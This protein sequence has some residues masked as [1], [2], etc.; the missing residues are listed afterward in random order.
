[1]SSNLAWPVTAT[2][3][4]G[5]FFQR[6]EP[7]FGVTLN[8]VCGGSGNYGTCAA[9]VMVPLVF[10]VTRWAWA[11]GISLGI[12]EA[13]FC[14]DSPLEESLAGQKDR[15]TF[16]RKGQ[17]SG[18]WQ[19]GGAL[20]TPPSAALVYTFCHDVID[21][22]ATRCTVRRHGHC[23]HL[24]G[25]MAPHETTDDQPWLTTP[26]EASAV[27]S[28]LAAI[29]A[30]PL[31]DREAE[32]ALID[33]RLSAAA[34]PPGTVVVVSGEPGVGKTRL[35]AA[36]AAGP[37][38]TV[39]GLRGDEHQRDVPYAPFL[40]PTS[41]FSDLPALLTSAPSIVIDP[42][43][44]RLDL[45]EQVD[46]LLVQRTENATCVLVVDDLQWL[47]AASVA[48][49][50]HVVRRGR[51]GGRA[52]LAT[53]RVGGAEADSPLG[54]L[55]A[56]W[57]RERLLLEIPLAPLTRSASDAFLTELLGSVARDLLDEVY[58][59]T[60]GLPYFIEELVRLL[61]TEGHAVLDAG[62]WRMTDSG[63]PSTTEV[64]FGITATVLRRLDN[65]PLETQRTLHA[66]AVLGTRFPLGL[67]AALVD[68]AES[69]LME[70]LGPAI[71]ARL[72]RLESHRAHGAHAQCSFTHAL[73]RDALYA[74][75][76]PDERRALHRRASDVLARTSMERSLGPAASTD[77]AVLAY[78]AERARAWQVAYEGSLLAGDAAVAVLA[79]HDA[80]THYNRA[81]EYALAGHVSTT[82]ADVLAL[83][84]RLVTTLRGIG[85]LE[86]A[87]TAS[88]LMAHRAI[89]AGDRAAEAW[90]WIQFADACTFTHRLEDAAVG[91]ERGQ[92]I[93]E[94]L[95]DNGLLAAALATHGVLLSARGLLD[96]AEHALR[97]AL[98]LADRAGNRA[99]SLKGLIYLGFTASWRG[100][101]RE[102][103]AASE[104]ATQVAEATHDASS[105]A[106]ARFSLALALAG[107][108]RYADAL[109]ILRDLLTF[110]T[111]SGEP[112]YAVRAPN[113]IGWIYR[114]L[115]LAEQALAWDERAVAESDRDGGIGRFKARANS[116]LNL[117]TDLILLGRLDEAEATL[118]HAAEAVDQSEYMRWRTRNRLTLCRGE[119]SLARGDSE[120]ALDIAEAAMT[121]A[122]PQRAAK[123][124]HQAH[125][126][127][128]RTLVAL[129]RY[130][131][132]VPQ[133]EQAAATAAAIE[134]RAGH[135]RSLT[136]LA[137]ALHRLGRLG[138]A[139]ERYT[140]AGVTIAAIAE[141]LRDP[142][143]S[144]A[145]LTAPSV[146]AVLAHAGP[147]ALPQPRERSETT[148][149]AIAAGLTPRE[150]DVLRLLAEGL[151]DRQ[152]AAALSIS[153][154][155][156]G[157]HVLH[158]LQKLDV[159]SRTAAAV[160]AVRHD[161]A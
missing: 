107:C 149:P 11:L 156:A 82:E 48:L 146:A 124:V 14:E 9:A 86:E 8:I 39:I 109:T 44:A 100:R 117:G 27:L 43:G 151:S 52:L 142:E 158:I 10:V 26:P 77:A 50:R 153:E 29:G 91:L 140:E 15:Q 114:E 73:A 72:V 54:Q 152:I 161:I 83:D 23:P 1:M 70:A 53:I 98:P 112:Y 49:L 132:A 102:A 71:A 13:F 36:A 148:G 62:A 17:E 159:N 46:R 115:T 103:I 101:F 67:L 25:L 110:A 66:A 19:V 6:P 141:D 137:G 93:A 37:D 5:G 2:P 118:N 55:L 35:A 125:D 116:L 60:D 12:S 33:A 113:T 90:A 120:R 130:V 145:F 95:A 3:V 122:I 58:A 31:V 38:R 16:V 56:E 133:F 96:E 104:E 87:T 18:L 24:E 64:P 51:R 135:W 40:D 30:T 126:L 134:Y 41:G 99:V 127:T 74:G 136:H 143:L 88:R 21:K 76:P 155:T 34:S 105:L 106:D 154:R 147:A 20:A 94:D 80:L 63:T 131:E 61:V 85:R 157:N 128:G 129:G 139:A 7:F 121:D 108:S 78:H 47:D 111:T 42:A 59:R 45:F 138:A 84:R 123:Y 92:A 81:R 75:L 150:S 28:V 68:G 57:N 69:E 79:G 65:L 144:A 32:R 4:T 160:F 119:L 89:A 22:A 97:Q